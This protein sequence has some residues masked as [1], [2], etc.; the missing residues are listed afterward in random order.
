MIKIK[1][2]GDMGMPDSRQGSCFPGKNIFQGFFAHNAKQMGMGLQSFKGQDAPDK[3]RTDF[4][5]PS[6]AAFSKQTADFIR[7]DFFHG[8]FAFRQK[9]FNIIL[10]IWFLAPALG[11]INPFTNRRFVSPCFI[12]GDKKRIL[13]THPGCAGKKNLISIIP[14]QQKNTP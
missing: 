10:Y 6:H 13:P 5:N 12:L 11:V 7:A 2:S 4:I 3:R 9:N 1:D 8:V 14:K